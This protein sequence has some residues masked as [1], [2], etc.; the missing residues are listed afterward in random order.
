MKTTLI[1]FLVLT[2][3]QLIFTETIYR[4][5]PIVGNKWEADSLFIGAT[6]VVRNSNI[7]VKIRLKW[8]DDFCAKGSLYFM[9]PTKRDSAI[10]LFDNN[11]NEKPKDSIFYT[12][13]TYQAGT[14]L[15][16]MYKINDT[17]Y[18]KANGKKLYTGQNRLGTNDYISDLFIGK[19]IGGYGALWAVAGRIDSTRIEVG[20]SNGENYSFRSM[21][22]EV[23][24]TSLL[25]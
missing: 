19:N 14:P 18:L 5:L 6:P 13:G 7:P 24:N 2:I 20:F 12:L 22:F 4:P 11:K 1:G 25:K 15:F 23:T 10:Y 16:F 9:C 21:V 17:M 3:S 8:N